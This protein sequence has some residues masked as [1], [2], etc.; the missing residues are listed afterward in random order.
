MNIQIGFSD[1]QNKSRKRSTSVSDQI[2]GHSKNPP[3]PYISKRSNSDVVPLNEYGNSLD[4]KSN[5]QFNTNI[6]DSQLICQL[7][8]RLHDKVTSVLK[9]CSNAEGHKRRRLLRVLFNDLSC[10]IEE[11]EITDVALPER[12]Y[13]LLAQYYVCYPLK[14]WDIIK[15]AS[16][17][18]NDKYFILIFS[19]LFYIWLFV[20][21]NN[22]PEHTNKFINV[23]VK[24]TNKVFWLDL[25]NSTQRYKAIYKYLKNDLV[26]KT[27][28]WNGLY[29]KTILEHFNL[30]SKFYFYYDT[31]DTL[32]EFLHNTQQS[33]VLNSSQFS[34]PIGHT[35]IIT[36]NMFINE[37]VRQL[38]A[39][40][41]EE[42]DETKIIKHAARLYYTW[43]S[44]LSYKE[45]PNASEKYS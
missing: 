3:N 36:L 19:I 32:K 10:R 38:R 35:K 26:L 9:Q 25:E 44:I 1:K 30:V 22:E 28:S 4:Q 18:Y 43:N 6:S 20:H 2:F 37:V 13:H 14:P 33:F 34:L 5:K 29:I 40:S 24:G 31:T 42:K 12:Y 23:F 39:I 27:G 45:G 8:E 15:Q 21:C 7:Q 16:T 17:L 11:L 41:S